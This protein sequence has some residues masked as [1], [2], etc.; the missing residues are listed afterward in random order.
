MNGMHTYDSPEQ[1]LEENR[2]LRK[3]NGEICPKCREITK[4]SSKGK[5]ICPTCDIMR[6]AYD[7]PRVPLGLLIAGGAFCVFFVL[8][9]I[10]LMDR[11][12]DGVIAGYFTVGGLSL[13]A[14]C[15]GAPAVYRQRVKHFEET[16]KN[17]LRRAELAKKKRAEE[18]EAPAEKTVRPSEA[19]PL[20]Y[21]EDLATVDHAVASG[22]QN[23]DR[24]MQG[25]SVS[26]MGV[27]RRRIT[28]RALAEPESLSL[29]AE[30]LYRYSALCGLHLTRKTAKELL[31]AMARNRLVFLSADHHADV[32]NTVAVLAGFFDCN[33]H[34]TQV[35]GEWKN[36]Y[37][38]LGINVRCNERE[39][40]CGGATG[41]LLDLYCANGNPDHACVTLLSGVDGEF[42]RNCLTPLMKRVKDNLSGVPCINLKNASNAVTLA[43]VNSNMTMPLSN[44][45]WYFCTAV[46]AETAVID[47]VPAA[48]RV[49]TVRIE[50]EVTDSIINHFPSAT[51]PVGCAD[52]VSICDAAIEDHFLS[53]PQWQKC[54]ALFAYLQQAL[55]F[56]VGNKDILAMEDASSLA[57]A[58][59]E[60]GEVY[61]LDY[62]ITSVIGAR[63][64]AASAQEEKREKLLRRIEEIFGTG[65][66]PG[67]TSLLNV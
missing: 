25:A 35:R 53:E 34:E 48:E 30:Q 59:F 5:T 12:S 37:D 6:V 54:D 66:L 51:D 61:A 63:L 2:A 20:A 18:G 19:A 52:F 7:P 56:K 31:I 22:G 27:L 65:A 10:L 57:L 8:S 28:Y 4:Y 23:A 21:F 39:T 43:H 47:G 42:L 40:T 46:E 67:L 55:G 9:G 36:E 24:F 1:Y 58:F 41:V 11:A 14:L 17:C 44:N 3:L 45:M 15:V 16:M 13:A 29:V 49:T 64:R 38:M 32:T 33:A 62:A 60:E 26:H 50:R